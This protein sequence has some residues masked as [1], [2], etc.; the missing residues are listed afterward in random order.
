MLSSW[1]PELVPAMTF[2]R[3]VARYTPPGPCRVRFGLLE[4][5][6][7]VSSHAAPSWYC[8]GL[9][10]VVHDIS[11][12]HISNLHDLNHSPVVAGAHGICCGSGMPSRSESRGGAQ[13]RPVSVHTGALACSVS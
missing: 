12:E 13:H 4:H 8:R 1:R 7:P 10:T 11:G 6:G 3:S 9:H 2:E 5:R